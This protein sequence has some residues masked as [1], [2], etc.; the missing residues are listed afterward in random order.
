[1]KCQALIVREC[2]SL[3]SLPYIFLLTI[4]NI[5]LGIWRVGWQRK[6]IIQNSFRSS[7][8]RFV[9]HSSG[10]WNAFFR[11][12]SCVA[13][14]GMETG[15]WRGEEQSPAWSQLSVALH[16]PIT[17]SPQPQSPLN[18]LSPLR[19]WLLYR[20]DRVFNYHKYTF[21][22][23]SSFWGLLCLVQSAYINTFSNSA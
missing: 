5:S 9:D 21:I 23:F 12:L 1:M 18:Y 22:K 19:T 2:K 20:P 17:I 15:D 14:S 11:I 7:R 10:V 8:W 16:H 4:I 6:R 13:M 3:P